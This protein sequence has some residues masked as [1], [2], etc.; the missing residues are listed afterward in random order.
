MVDA[1]QCMA[2]P[3]MR[4]NS[5]G[6]MM[7]W[8]ECCWRTGICGDCPPRCGPHHQSYSHVGHICTEAQAELWRF[9]IR[10]RSGSCT[11]LA[12]HCLWVGPANTSLPCFSSVDGMC[13]VDL[14]AEIRPYFP[15][16]QLKVV[17]D[18]LVFRPTVGST[19][20]KQPTTPYLYLP[21]TFQPR[22]LSCPRFP[23]PS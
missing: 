6:G 1:A 22:P 23:S 7:R 15:Y 19:L 10:S 20:C 5:A 9:S 12:T 11:R 4:L 2:E 21:L 17:A 3:G 18:V 16:I 8:T 14:Q 13:L